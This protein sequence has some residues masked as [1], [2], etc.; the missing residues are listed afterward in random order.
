MNGF[1]RR[2]QLKKES[3]RQAAAKLFLQNSIEKVAIQEIAAAA[4]VS[5]A[6]I[7]KYYGSKQDLVLEVVKWAYE[8]AYQEIE[9]ILKSDK[10]FLER[11]QEMMFHKNKL[12]DN[13][14]LD[15]FRR[16]SS[17]SPQ[18]IAKVD[19]IYEGKKNK[20]YAEFIQEGKQK[21]YIHPEVTTDSIIFFRNGLR[22]LI[23]ANPDILAEF[24]HNKNL[25]KGYMRILLFGV[26]GKEELP[27]IHIT[28]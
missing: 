28:L 8:Q 3:I 20:L 6:T 21:G 15:L 16:A 18:E 10:P 22:A 12:L 11:I 26:M 7:F 23:L 19:A 27:D 5:Y 14:D 13:A 9:N 1:E 25:L 2:R 4:K 24:K 17:Y